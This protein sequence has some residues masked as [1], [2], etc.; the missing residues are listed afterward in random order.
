MNNPFLDPSFA[1]DWS[2][3]TPDKVVPDMELALERA[4]RNLAAIRSLQPSEATFDNVVKA[5]R[6]ALDELNEAWGRVN[7]LDAVRNSDELRAAYNEML[8]KVTAF[9]AKI[10]LDQKLW[11]IL[12]AFSETEEAKALEGTDKRLFEETVEDFREEGADLPPEKRERLEA[13]STEL[14]QVTQKF[15]ENVLDATNSWDLVIEDEEKLAGLPE[16]A[17]A[18]ARQAAIQKLG[19]NEGQSRWRFTLHI[20]SMMPLLQYLDDDDLRRQVWEASG[21]VGRESE[22]DNTE[23]I[24]KIL[25]LRTEKAGLLGK[26]DFA[27]VVLSRRMAKNGARA[28]DFV[29]DLQGKTAEA[30]H[31]E[32]EELEAYKA[33]ETGQ[34]KEL[35]EPW[36]V[37]YWIEKRKKALFDFDDEELR[38]YFPIDSVLG[39][40][41]EL[42]TK[43]FGLRI[44]ERSTLFEG[45]AATTVEAN[46]SEPAEVWHP[47]VKF[48]DVFDAENDRHMGSFY[49][50]WH[51]RESKRGGAWMNSLRTGEPNE[52]DG[53]P[54]PHL[55]LMCGNM[56]PSSKGKPALLTHYE[57][58]T[59]F[60]EFGHLMHHLCGEVKYKDLNGTN[61]AWDFVEL[62]SQIMENWCWER[63]SLDLFA[64]HHETGNPIPEELFQKMLRARNYMAGNAMMRQLA[65]GK[66]DLELHRRMAI[67]GYE[68]LETAIEQAL[69]GY[70]AQRKT[71]PPSGV[72]RFN[73]LFSSPVGYAAAYY[74]YKW[75]EVLD[76]DAFTR[77][78]KEGIMDSSVGKAFRKDILSKGNSEPP[79]DLFRA[80]MG[81]DPDPQALLERSGLASS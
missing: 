9:Y 17:Q 58:E 54:S 36:A 33:T 61:V 12:K 42:V 2:E 8:P 22:R 70:V 38:P 40:M 15:A 39:G 56:T 18:N 24:R 60:H 19:E 16:V 50:D 31:R 49:A 81:R 62:P 34:A 35:L 55:G 4:E 23:L 57:V 69:E 1:I 43:V 44:K 78:Q 73:H 76:A 14:A 20:P 74:S 26:K 5:G 51:P 66:M 47:E 53:L 45:A 37:S 11:S 79:E 48:Y 29:S 13:L 52:E 72:H 63:E 25:R 46:E 21:Q 3:L 28:D 59:V 32:N 6:E 27:D 80:F 64:R 68:D 30:F 77:F 71:K 41:F 75:A 10:P 7:H 67:D 65:F